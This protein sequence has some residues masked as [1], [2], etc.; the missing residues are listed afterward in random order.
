MLG[1]YGTPNW[2]ISGEAS[3]QDLVF[4]YISF[5]LYIY[6]SLFYII[7]VAGFEPATFCWDR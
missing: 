3:N 6:R 5:L 4:L 7:R 2:Y 1:V